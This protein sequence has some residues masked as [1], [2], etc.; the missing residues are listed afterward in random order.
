M[1]MR[2]RDNRINS[3]VTASPW[4]IAAWLG[5]IL[6]AAA[7]AAAVVPSFSR[8]LIWFCSGLFERISRD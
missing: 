1:G 7:A 3:N 8:D 5:L 2:P 4:N 6:A